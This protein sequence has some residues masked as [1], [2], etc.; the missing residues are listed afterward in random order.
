MGAVTVL[1]AGLMAWTAS[2][3]VTIPQP[4]T[5]LSTP[6]AMTAAGID[7]NATFKAVARYDYGGERKP[8]QALEL[9]VRYAHSLAGDDPQGFRGGLA[10]RMTALLTSLDATPAAKIFVCG[11]LAE[12]ASEKQAPAVNSLLTNQPL[13]AAAA[14]RALQRI[15]GS[16]VDR[17][18]RDALAALDGELKIGVVGALGARR[19]AAATEPL[20]AMLAGADQ[21][22]AGA[23]ADALGRIGGNAAARA[24]QQSLARAQGRLRLEVAAACLTCADRLLADGQNAAAAAWY[25]RLSGE[26]ET[27]PVRMAAWRGTIRSNPEQGLGAVCAALASGDPALESMGLHLVPEVSGTGATEQLAKCLAQVSSPVRALLLGAL[28]A[29]GDVAARGVVQK[30]LSSQD[31]AVRLA[32]INAL[33]TLGDETSV[34][35]L[36]DRTKAGGSAAERQAAQQ[37]LVRLRGPRTSEVLTGLLSQEDPSQQVGLIRVLAARNAVSSLPALEKA[38]EAADG[39]VRKEAWKALGTLARTSDM[40]AL[41]DLLVRVRDGERDGAE[42]SVGAVLRRPDRLDLRAMLGKLDIVQT[43]AARGSLIRLLG[44]VGDDRALPP[45]RQA[46]QSGDAGVRDAAV[47]ALAAWP[48]P[49]PFA[50]LVNL[51]RTAGEPVHR[52]LALRAAIRLSGKVEGH[53]PE[54]MTGLI[55]ELM[56]LA[57]LTPERKAVLA[58]LGRCP[59]LDALRLAQKYQ[60]DPELAAEAGLAVTQIASALRDTHRD[61]VLAALQPMLTGNRDAAIAAR[62][63]KILKDIL[64][65]VNLALGATATSPDG[66][67]SDGASGGDQAAIDGDPN[68]YWDEVDGADLYRLKVTLKEPQDVSSI[69]ILWHHYEQYQARNLD[70]L[71]DGRVVAEARGAK[72]FENEMFI[73]FRSVRCTSVELVIPGKNGLVSPAIH[74]FQIFSHFPHNAAG[75]GNPGTKVGSSQTSDDGWKP[76]E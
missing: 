74:E 72:C 43:T 17:M 41:L 34:K 47:R 20:I 24:L 62:A 76:R 23:A 25:A 71:C 8:L 64:K 57:G 14:L 61:Q 21:T 70:V 19:D 3:Q 1:A 15:P 11:Q 63:C 44:A 52:V 31:P 73:A 60:V 9:L 66:L 58:E 42:E 53:T 40:P 29:R 26:T 28:A 50:D 30:A 38:A 5:R 35:A 49:T 48:T 16:T 39:A 67:D 27:Q 2:S 36:V 32:A 54:Q 59:T 65:P 75:S 45:L 22:L 7:L 68:T 33:G 10:D 4:A 6:A 46:V 12:I 51:A 37:S 55:A 13:V 56:H 18:L 69:N